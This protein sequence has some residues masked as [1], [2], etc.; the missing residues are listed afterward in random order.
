S[1]ADIVAGGCAHADL[2]PN[3]DEDSETGKRRIMA[4]LRA[5][6]PLASVVID[7]GNGIQALWVLRGPP[8][9]GN[10][11]LAAVAARHRHLGPTCW[12]ID[13]LLRVPGTVNWPNAKKK[14]LGRVPVLSKLLYFGNNTY[15]L[16]DLPRAA[17]NGQHK[18][19]PAHDIP[20]ELPRI[21]S[22]EDIP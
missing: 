22:L 11:A 1:K 3:D 6:R 2:Y 9:L 8:S 14:R 20:D 7:S 13:R 15:D 17:V 19:E 12:N 21:E 5:V 16:A 18:A 10:G 4:A